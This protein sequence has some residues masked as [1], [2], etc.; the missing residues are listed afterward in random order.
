MALYRVS[1]TSR[2]GVE[3]YLDLEHE[4]SQSALARTTAFQSVSSL[5]S[6]FNPTERFCSVPKFLSGVCTDP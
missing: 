3:A 5:N 6:S 1:A 4:E 2:L